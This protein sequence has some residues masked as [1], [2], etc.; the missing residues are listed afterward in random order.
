MENAN[1]R[2]IE[3]KS[4]MTL[5]LL[6]HFSAEKDLEICLPNHLSECYPGCNGCFIC[7]CDGGCDEG[8]NCT[9][10]CVGVKF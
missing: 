10:T 7:D 1:V 5:P 9:N 6:N 2:A 4:F 8:C 3:K